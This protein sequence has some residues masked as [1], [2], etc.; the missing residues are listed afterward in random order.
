M[1][2]QILA[3]GAMLEGKEVTFMPSYGPEMRGGTAN[4]TVVISDTPIASPITCDID[5]LVAMNGSSLEKFQ[6]SVVPGG[7]IFVNSGMVT[8]KIERQDVEAFYVNGMKMANDLFENEKVAN[9][10]LL[11]AVLH[12]TQLIPLDHMESVF[13]KTLKGK[14]AELIQLNV[15]AVKAW[16]NQ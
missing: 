11:G 4:C 15:E 5:I 6:N 8:G 9:V 16:G 2:G 3:Y 7:K 12:E 10:V 13:K 14:K 1:M